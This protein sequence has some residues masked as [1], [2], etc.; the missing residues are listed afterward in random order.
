MSFYKI[1]LF[2]LYFIHLKTM[3][4]NQIYKNIAIDILNCSN[5]NFKWLYIKL[6]PLFRIDSIDKENDYFVKPNDCRWWFG[7]SKKQRYTKLSKLVK[8][9]SRRNMSILLEYII[10]LRSIFN[11]FVPIHPVSGYTFEKDIFTQGRYMLCFN[12]FITNKII[13][14][15]DDTCPICYNEFNNNNFLITKCGHKFCCDCIF[16]HFQ[17]N[18]GDKCPLCRTTFAEKKTITKNNRRRIID[19]DDDFDN[20]WRNEII[21]NI[22]IPN[23][24]GF[25]YTYTIDNDNVSL[26]ANMETGY[27]DDGYGDDI[28][29]HNLHAISPTITTDTALSPHPTS[30][31]TFPYHEVQY[32]NLYNSLNIEIPDN[33]NID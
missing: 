28:L 3:T 11:L 5:D 9:G 7:D 12:G 10:E 30:T 18:N 6:K 14:T 2:F 24:D 31:V 21:E 19:D 27:G 26:N 32:V 13:K 17:N 8:R 20:N 16:E 23:N 4:D 29:N 15:P 33:D 22:D 25:H 1:D